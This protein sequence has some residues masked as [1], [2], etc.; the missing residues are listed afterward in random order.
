VARRLR[1]WALPVVALLALAVSAPPDE[2]A[3]AA[4]QGRCAGKGDRAGRC[5]DAHVP[6]RGVTTGRGGNGRPGRGP[7]PAPAKLGAVIL[8]GRRTRT[9]ACRQGALPD[10][11]CSPGAYYS[12]LTTTVLCAPTFRAAALGAI[13]QRVVSAVER[14]Y[15][16]R[17]QPARTPIVIDQIV[18]PE[19]GGATEIA[20]LFPEP[21]SGPADASSKNRLETRL[22]QLVCGGQITLAA[23]RTAIAMNWKMLYRLVFHSHP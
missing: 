19:L 9:R 4:G 6:G 18:P 5:K 20:N 11:R 13:D 16:L 12:G 3:G 14:E 2:R 23:A 8:L 7:R 21:A 15:G 1:H 17:P 22:H 10:R